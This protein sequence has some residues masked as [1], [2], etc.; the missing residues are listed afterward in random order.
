MITLFGYARLGRDAELRY[1]TNND[2]VMN[3]SLAFNYGR[4]DESGKKP[5]Q[6]IDASLWGQR[7]E[8]LAEYMLKGQGLVVT[9]EDLHIEQFK[10]RDGTPG[11]KLVG[12]VSTIEFAGGQPQQQG[13]APA[14]AP[15]NSNSYAD[16]KSG[17]AQPPK[18]K[19]GSGFDDM[20]DDIPF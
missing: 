1:T 11:S 20:D 3:L 17:R 8:A 19:T 2:P 10:A 5:V 18:Q 7:A 15:R 14:P 13:A 9:L 12:R 6:W 4:K 16:A